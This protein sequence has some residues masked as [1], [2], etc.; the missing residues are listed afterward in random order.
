MKQS[1]LMEKYPVFELTVP[2]AETTCAD[3]DAVIDRL[4]AR[5]EAHPKVAYIATFDHF[6]HT[7]AIGGSIAPQIKAAK[8]IV[9]CFGVHL[10]NPHVLAVRPRAIGVADLGDSF[11]L[12]FLEPP[13]ELAT[14]EMEAWCKALADRT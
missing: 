3:I 6:A 12:A 11:H 13:M 7:S 5:I 4:R 1:I 10:P 9:F 14:T 8:N 2:K